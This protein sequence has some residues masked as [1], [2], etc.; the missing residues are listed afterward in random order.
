M[1]NFAEVSEANLC[2]DKDK[3]NTSTTW[4]FMMAYIEVLNNT[5]VPL[6]ELKQDQMAGFSP[7]WTRHVREEFESVWFFEADGYYFQYPPQRSR[8]DETHGAQSMRNNTSI[9]LLQR[10]K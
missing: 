10:Q 6:Q 2:Y 7:L 5:Y 3:V 8:M 4:L 1:S 9:W